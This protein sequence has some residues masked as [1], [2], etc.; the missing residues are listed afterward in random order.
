[1]FTTMYYTI[2]SNGVD[3][4]V[5]R[6]HSQEVDK[7]VNP[8]ELV[9]D[10][11]HILLSEDV[12]VP[13]RTALGTRGSWFGVMPSSGL[14]YYAV[15]LVGVY[16]ENPRHGLPLIRGILLL[17]DARSGELL[18]EADAAPA[19]GWRTASASALALELMGF[20]GGGVLG[21]IGAGVQGSY[22]LEVLTRIYPFDKILIHD[23]DKSKAEKLSERFRDFAARV[24][25]R[26][27]VQK[28]SNV[29]V[30]A[31]TSTNPV[32]SAQI[33]SPG[34][35]IVSI[36]APKPVRELDPEIPR[37]AGCVLV[38]TREGVE[39]E[40]EDAKTAYEL[41]EMREVLRGEKKFCGKEFKVYK[42]VGTALFDLAVAIH[43]YRRSSP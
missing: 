28:E 1:M 15:K 42:S 2:S 26:E 35:Y 36:G 9:E 24:A 8:I 7:T 17:F 39:N 31:T 34:T 10:I 11:R 30:T 23:T 16:P 37:R 43:L 38:D 6:L 22:H 21:L 41:I 13:L 5:V 33:V 20:R 19:T 18:L 14:G 40:S 27:D 3:E 32:L 29:I 4:L 12:E 25:S